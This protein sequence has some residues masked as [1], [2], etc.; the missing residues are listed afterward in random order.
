MSFDPFGPVFISYRRS[1]GNELAKSLSWCLQAA[2]VP[3]WLDQNDLPPGDNERRIQEALEAGLSGAVLVVTP[4]IA[5]SEVVPWL[6]LPTL[7]KLEEDSRFTLSV[8]ST[9]ERTPGKLDYERADTVLH[10]R[11]G[12]LRAFEQEPVATPEQRGKLALRQARRRAINLRDAVHT[13]GAFRVHLKTRT[14]TFPTYHPHFDV[15]IRPSVSPRLPDRQGLLDLKH[16]IHGLSDSAG[17]AQARVVRFEGR[18]HLSVGLALG[19]TFPTT[20]GIE[21][22]VEAP[23]GTWALN[24]KSPGPNRTPQLHLDEKVLGGKSGSPILVFVG[25]TQACKPGPAEQFADD[26]ESAF[27]RYASFRRIDDRQ[28]VLAADGDAL[29]R[30]L[31]NAIRFMASDARTSEVHLLLACTLPVAIMLGQTL[32]TLTVHAYELGDDD[33]YLPSLVA[34]PGGPDPIQEVT[35][36]HTAK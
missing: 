26:H 27:A 30:E 4:E 18:A 20:L 9:L 15:R 21:V 1:D 5:D 34:C 36:P 35:L 22:Q 2:G 16:A 7:Q 33:R 28:H 32:N 8:A 11:P 24:P 31:S 14:Q 17:K 6:E 10:Q 12:T 25:I 23:D 19:C 29:V 3:V 13:D